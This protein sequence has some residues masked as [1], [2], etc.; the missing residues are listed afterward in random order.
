ML[1]DTDGAALPNTNSQTA[2]STHSPALVQSLISSHGRV[3]PWPCER[4]CVDALMFMFG[5]LA[6][7]KEC[8]FKSG[9]EG[10]LFNAPPFSPYAHTRTH[11]H[12]LCLTHT[13]VH[14]YVHTYTHGDM[15]D[16]VITACTLYSI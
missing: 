13:L 9:L 6:M 11:M 8:L 5:R 12:A 14:V 7:M 3:T 16:F 1:I 4:D 10:P 15:C 2:R